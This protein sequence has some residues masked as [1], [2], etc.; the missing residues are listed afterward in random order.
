MGKTKE[1]TPADEAAAA[2]TAT[3]DAGTDKVP[4]EPKSDETASN[5]V[6]TAEAAPPAEATP[7]APVE[8]S[9]ARPEGEKVAESSDAQA[10]PADAS[11]DSGS[12]AST[13]SSTET[14][15][16]GTPESK[17]AEVPASDEAAAPAAVT[18]A[19]EAKKVA[20]SPEGATDRYTVQP[21]DT[22]M[23]IAFETYG[24]LYKW[25]DLYEAN[26]DRIK[27]PNYIP[28]GTVLSFE[29]PS[30]PVMIERNGEKY[31][32]K[33]GDTLG[34]I[35]GDVYGTRSKWKRL[36]E[37][38]RK[39]IKNPNMIFAGF[40]LYYTM[41]PEDRQELEQYRQQQ[42]MP[43]LAPKPLA[44]GTSV[45]L[46][47]ASVALPQAQDGTNVATGMSQPGEAPAP[48]QPLLPVPG[49]QQRAP[50][51]VTQ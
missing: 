8:G 41:T 38:N 36:W 39:L 14:T 35:S 23:K 3:A 49:Q 26:K 50:A 34:S 27:N 44:G 33:R 11:P 42:E 51:S 10:T 45:P 31:L 13:A 9:E 25:K 29:K 37:N 47:P 2:E 1:D 40:H 16:A 6:K 30:S 18:P 19:P 15:T 20:Q 17:V 12:T 43:Q 22:L 5:E 4:E 24:D 7:D 46:L 48:V 32:I 21:G 28:P